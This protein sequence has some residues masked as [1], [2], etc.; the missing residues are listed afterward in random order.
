MDKQLFI[1]EVKTKS[2]FELIYNQNWDYKFDIANKLGDIISIH[3]EAP[4]NGSFDL[5]TKAKARTNKPIL[6]KGYHRSILDIH[7]SFLCGADMVLVIRKENEDLLYLLQLERIG[8]FSL[9]EKEFVIEAVDLEQLAWLE[10]VRF[11][12][13]GLQG[14]LVVWNQ[15]NLNS[16]FPKKETFKEAREIYKGKL[17]Q[18]SLIKGKTDIDPNADGVLIGT[19][20]EEFT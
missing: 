14:M 20:L 1:A 5:I 10:K 19:N 7:N 4:W 16:G 8:N 12:Y 2:P 17:I 6:A 18:A 13:H 11:D 9:Y 3:T 15:R